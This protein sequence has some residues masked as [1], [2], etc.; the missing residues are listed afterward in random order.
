MSWGDFDNAQNKTVVESAAA[1][2]LVVFTLIYVFS[3]C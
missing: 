2:A 1:G 3:H